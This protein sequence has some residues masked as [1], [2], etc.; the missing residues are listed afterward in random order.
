MALKKRPGLLISHKETIIKVSLTESGRMA[1][2]TMSDS[3]SQ[4]EVSKLTSNLLRSGRWKH[5]KFSGLDVSANVHSHSFGR[6]HPLNDL[7]REIKEIFISMG[8]SEIDGP[9]IQSSFWNFD[10]LFTPQDHPAR[11]MQDTF[12]LSNRIP[13]EQLRHG[14][15]E[16][17]F[18]IS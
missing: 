5:T 16:K 12:Y 18:P 9:F 13:A 17:S 11:E 4:I 6:I 2:S 1:T 3:N 10:V 7:I 8:F 15:R 14:S